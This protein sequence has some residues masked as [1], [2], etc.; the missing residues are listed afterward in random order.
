M[1]LREP[2][3]LARLAGL[4]QAEFLLVR[5]DGGSISLLDSHVGPNERHAHNHRPY[6]TIDQMAL[7]VLGMNRKRLRYQD[8][9]WCMKYYLV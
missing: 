8:H 6:D 5:H 9:P 3:Q 7:I 4:L 2:G 1:F